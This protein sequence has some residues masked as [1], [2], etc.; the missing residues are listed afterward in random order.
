MSVNIGSLRIF[1]IDFFFLFFFNIR[2]I[3][4]TTATNFWY[5]WNL[6]T[7]FYA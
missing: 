7:D 2:E 4:N 3:S 5:K 6:I 1:L